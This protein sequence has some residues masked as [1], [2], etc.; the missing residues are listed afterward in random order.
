MLLAAGRGERMR[1]ITDSVPKPLVQVAGRAL[2][3][4]VVDAARAE[5]LSRFVVNAHHLAPQIAGWAATRAI[6]V[7]HEAELLNT[8]GGVMNALPL[9]GTDPILVMHT[10]SFW[11]AGADRPIARLIERWAV[12]D[13]DMALLCVHPRNATGFRLSHDF[14]LDPSGHIT[15]DSGAPVIYAGACIV[16][17]AMFA[18]RSGAFSMARL[19]EAAG[20]RGRLVGAVLDAPWLHVGDAEAIAEAEAR[21][22]VAA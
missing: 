2:L 4:H 3:D 13:A 1:P 11:P 14:C 10:D 21:L 12:G 5:G 6:A 22:E 8:G 17:R 18:G 7:S 20:E 15:R 9:L 16:G 19:Y